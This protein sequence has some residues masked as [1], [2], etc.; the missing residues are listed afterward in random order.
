ML[1]KISDQLN[2]AFISDVHLGH[3]RT[4]TKH[5][6]G[7]LY[8]AFPNN[9]Q[10]RALDVICIVGDL[11]D[12]LLTAPDPNLG[13][14]ITWMGSFLKQC[15]KND[16]SIILLEGTPSH[17]WAQNRLMVDINTTG[18]IGADLH[19]VDTLSILE[20][21]GYTF[22]CVPDE[23]RPNP[24]DTWKDVCQQLQAHG[25]SQVD[26]SLVHGA[27]KYQLP[28]IAK[29]PTHDPERYES[30]TRYVA[31]IGHVHK[32][33]QHGRILSNGSFDRL[34]H[35]EEEPKG[36]WR[37]RLYRPDRFEARFVEN[38]DAMIYRTVD[39]RGLTLEDALQAL[40][41]LDTQTT[42]CYVRIAAHTD[43]AI[44]TNLSELKNTYPEVEFSNSVD[45]KTR[46]QTKL[47]VDMRAEF[48]QTAITPAN[49]SEL[50]IGRLV[51]QGVDAQ[52]VALCT[53][54][55]SSMLD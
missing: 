29:A 36:H 46:V 49:V 7:N 2:L 37:V 52:T 30:I 5:I 19:Y 34:A 39:C 25:L 41:F 6:V 51:R 17:D 9:E 53:Q 42:R 44:I 20:L 10:T 16:T 28:E 32:H 18:E 22:L 54:Y 12:Q 11:F 4:P 47:L 31:D 27:F 23:W 24:D 14:I 15:K 55:L 35:G 21:R 40:S 3:N 38:T 43:D 33:S 13:V 26:V 50:L 8:R 48:H 1:T 45:D